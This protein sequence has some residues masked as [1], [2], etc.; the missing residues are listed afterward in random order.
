ML[1]RALL[2]HELDD[3]FGRRLAGRGHTT[4][5]TL[6]ALGAAEFAALCTE[7]GVTS[8]ETRNLRKRLRQ[9][10]DLQQEL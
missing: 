10:M 9:A 3:S 1:S 8:R 6:L 2:E 4:A 7:I 5:A